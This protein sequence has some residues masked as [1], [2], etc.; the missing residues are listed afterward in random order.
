LVDL[1]YNQLGYLEGKE[2]NEVILENGKK[3]PKEVVDDIKVF[4]WRWGLGC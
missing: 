4:S 2:R 1:A 3:E